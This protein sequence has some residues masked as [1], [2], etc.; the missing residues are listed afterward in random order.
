VFLNKEEVMS[1]A[2]YVINHCGFYQQVLDSGMD[3]ADFTEAVMEQVG[4]IVEGTLAG[5]SVKPHKFPGVELVAKSVALHVIEDGARQVAQDLDVD[6][7]RL[8]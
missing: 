7:D 5:K 6:V 8:K 3:S 2:D 1:N 4:K